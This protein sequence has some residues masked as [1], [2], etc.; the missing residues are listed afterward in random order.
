MNMEKRLK[1]DNQ[2][3]LVVIS[4]LALLVSAY[5]LYQHYSSGSSFCDIG[6]NLNCDIVN[7]GIYSDVDGVFNYLF[8][9]E[10][11]LPIPNALLSIVFFLFILISSLISQRYK[12]QKR[13]SKITRVLFALALIYTLLLFHIQVDVLKTFCVFCLALDVLIIAAFLNVFV[14]KNKI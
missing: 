5:L 10:L 11:S 3:I 7:K 13:I 12:T 6:E 2:K 4:I 9:T 14:K 1:R 8:G